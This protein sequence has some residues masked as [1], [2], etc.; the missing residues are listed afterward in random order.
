MITD[1]LCLLKA[2]FYL[3]ICLLLK[4]LQGK[5]SHRHHGWSGTRS[6]RSKASEAAE[7]KEKSENRCP[8]ENK[9]EESFLSEDSCSNCGLPNYPELVRRC[10]GSGK[11][12]VNIFVSLFTVKETLTTL[13]VSNKQQ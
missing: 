3:D 6:K 8:E 10:P 5:R 7:V 11:V 4:I 13:V 2:D 9:S 12:P 1:S